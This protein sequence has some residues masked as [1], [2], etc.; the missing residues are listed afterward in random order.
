VT[1]GRVSDNGKG[2]D[3]KRV[4]DD[5]RVSDDRKRFLVNRKTRGE[6]SQDQISLWTPHLARTLLPCFHL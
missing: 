6:P 2:E 1:A 5:T 3:D 4:S